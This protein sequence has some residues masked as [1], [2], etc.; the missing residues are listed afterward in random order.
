[1]QVFG[2]V[3]TGLFAALTPLW[4]AD[5]TRGT[6][7]YNFSQGAMATM[8]GL[9]T[10]TSGLVSELMVEHLGYVPAFLGCGVIG[11]AAA[12]LLWL[13]L[14]ERQ[15]SAQTLAPSR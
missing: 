2:G 11:A 4:L 6:G 1:V 5:A 10:T 8:R 3:G 14:P 7:R 15:A 9:G 12:M 13:G